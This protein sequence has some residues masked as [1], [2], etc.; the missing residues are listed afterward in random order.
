MV[1]GYKLLATGTI[2]ARREFQVHES[3]DNKAKTNSGRS[4]PAKDK[5]AQVPV[6]IVYVN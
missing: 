5:T 6:L 4:E 3:G 2:P 1:P